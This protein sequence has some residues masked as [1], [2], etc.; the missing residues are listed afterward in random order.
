QVT[1]DPAQA[2]FVDLFMLEKVESFS[3][4]D[5]WI[6]RLA[7]ALSPERRQMNHV[8][9]NGLYFA[10]LPTK[11]YAS[12]PD[13]VDD[14]ALQ[15]PE[16]WIERMLDAY[17]RMEPANGT[18]E[19]PGRSEI[20]EDVDLYL[21]YLRR[22]FSDEMVDEDV[23]RQVHAW[24][25][26]P[27]FMQEVVIDHLRTM[28]IEHLAAAWQRNL[29]L[30]EECLSAFGQADWPTGSNVEIVRWVTGQELNAWY[31]S[32]VNA[33]KSIRLV[34]SAHVGPYLGVIPGGETIWIVFGAR[35][36]AGMVSGRSA[37]N[38]S[39]LLMRLSALADGNR[40]QMLELL[41]EHDE[42]CAQD[43]IE[44]L[45][46]S[47]SSASRHL[48]QLSASGYVLERRQD[49]AKCYRL[50]REQVESTLI[51]L[52]RFFGLR[53]PGAVEESIAAD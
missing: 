38:R 34:P 20:L 14:L 36:P 42:L 41:V 6:E 49:S 24:M 29:P 21:A 23:E 28:W 32:E 46:L 10:L 27:K 3:G 8:V 7:S 53:S 45:D 39:D 26:A 48:R 33:A 47:Q 35:L 40:L 30:L 2:A 13:Y 31:E 12:F 1:L 19:E 44:R 22:R 43:L 15:P 51:A 4:L 11:R 18:G 17:D 52:D 25:G 9:I 5:P 37:L 50:H 16:T